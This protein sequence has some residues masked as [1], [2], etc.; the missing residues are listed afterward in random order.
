MLDA[1]ALNRMHGEENDHVRAHTNDD[2]NAW[3]DEKTEEN[4]RY[5]SAQGPDAIDER[6][7][8]LDREWDVERCL[9]VTAS[10][11]SLT[12]VIAALT[13]RKKMLILP[14]VVLAFLFQHAVQGW[15]PPLPVFRRFGI[16]TRKEIDREKYALKVL[17]GDF[18]G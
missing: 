6:I 16:R 1:G 10:S 3:I 4:I 9:E 17:R 12:G 18:A 15:C 14:A 2:V 7:R 5:W 13:G 8:A 11:L